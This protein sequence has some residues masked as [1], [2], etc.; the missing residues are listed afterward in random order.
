MS[1]LAITVV[2]IYLSE[3]RDDINSL[4]TWL[5]EAD[6]RGFTVFRGVAGMG[7]HHH[8]HTAS[9]IDLSS[10]LPLIVEFFDTP[11]KIETICQ[12]LKGKVEAE[13]IISWPAQTGI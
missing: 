8:L 7:S 11:E 1:K 12:Q 6:V 2:R 5:E 9:L 10:E 13:H 4:L 3:G